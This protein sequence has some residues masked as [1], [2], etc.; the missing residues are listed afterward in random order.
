VIPLEHATESDVLF[1]GALASQEAN[2]DPIDLAFLAA[3]KERH[4][5]DGVPAVTPVSFAPFDTKNRRTEAVVEQNGE[6]LRVMK[7]AVRTVAQACGLQPATIEALEAR[8]SGSALRGYRTLAV[9]RGPET[10]TT[11]LVGLVTLYDPPRPDAKQL[12]AALHDL[13]VPVKMLT[14]DALTVASEIAQEVGLP[15]IRRVADLKAAGI[16]GG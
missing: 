4:V 12:I 16:S 3:A 1:A 8:V 9:A 5:F 2:Q 13:G 14:G 7:G 11:A 15:N 6:R 10:G